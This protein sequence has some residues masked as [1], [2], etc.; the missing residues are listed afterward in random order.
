VSGGDFF[1]DLPATLLPGT[2]YCELPP[3]MGL[4]VSCFYPSPARR[5]TRK[6]PVP[7]GRGKDIHSVSPLPCQEKS[8]PSMLNGSLVGPKARDA[9]YARITTRAR[10]AS[11]QF[12][13]E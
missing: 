8:L 10:A 12:H 7:F 5:I 11:Q 2:G 1:K 3:A 4:C 9:E 13:T 6:L